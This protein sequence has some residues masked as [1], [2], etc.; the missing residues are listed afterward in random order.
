MH[1]PVRVFVTAA[2]RSDRVTDA[3]ASSKG[4]WILLRSASRLTFHRPAG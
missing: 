1:S 4:D 3:A 2:D